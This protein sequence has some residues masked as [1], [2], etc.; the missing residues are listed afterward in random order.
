MKINVLVAWVIY[1]G[2]TL[3]AYGLILFLPPTEQ[4]GPGIKVLAS[5]MITTVIFLF[6]FPLI[7]V[8]NTVLSKIGFTLLSFISFITPVLFVSYRFSQNIKRV[9]TM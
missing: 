7:Q 8:Y 2:V 9:I 6:L 4:L 5:F 3:V 1:I